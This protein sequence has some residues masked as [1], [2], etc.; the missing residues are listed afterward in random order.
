MNGDGLI[1]E[2]DLRAT[3]DR[4][5]LDDDDDDDDD[6][7]DVVDQ[8]EADPE[9]KGS[10]ASR[11]T[12][13]NDN[14]EPAQEDEEGDD[15]FDPLSKLWE[16]SRRVEAGYSR[17]YIIKNFAFGKGNWTWS[18][19]P[20][21]MQDKGISGFVTDPSDG[22]ATVYATGKNCISKSYDH[23]DS[24][25]PCWAIGDLLNQNVK[26]LYIKDS[27][28]MIITRNTGAPLRTKDGRKTWQ[29]MT[30]LAAVPVHGMHWSWSGK[31][32]AMFGNGGVQNMTNHPHTAYV[33]KS[34]DDGDTW[35]DETADVVTM[36]A[37]I[38]QWY[39]KDLYL[40]SGGQGIM[41]KRFED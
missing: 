19:L 16:R 36:G 39:D 11:W 30:S 17:S 9:D 32:L 3:Q 21:F 31:T 18:L 37:G 35:T 29:E 5:P 22:G 12:I 14:D 4:P 28:T 40:S 15:G 1:D 10:R 8:E 24:W 33:W 23:G 27:K 34:T 25:E 38:S 7:E 2:Y 20:E 6:D 13:L 41:K 26:N